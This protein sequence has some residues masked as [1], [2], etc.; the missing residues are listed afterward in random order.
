MRLTYFIIYFLAYLLNFTYS[1]DLLEYLDTG[2]VSNRYENNFRRLT[3]DNVTI[4]KAECLFVQ[5]KPLSNEILK[6]VVFKI[7]EMDLND[8]A[9]PSKY[10]HLFE[11]ILEHLDIRLLEIVDQKLK[12]SKD[13][14]IQTPKNLYFL[15]LL[16]IKLHLLSD[17][18]DYKNFFDISLQI[19]RKLDNIIWLSLIS[20]LVYSNRIKTKDIKNIIRI[21]KEQYRNKL[22]DKDYKFVTFSVLGRFGDSSSISELSKFQR[23]GFCF[24]N[25]FEMKTFNFSAINGTDFSEIGI[26]KIA[27]TESFL[28]IYNLNYKNHKVY[29]YG[30]IN[31]KS[32]PIWKSYCRF[33]D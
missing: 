5:Q 10:R 16:K 19:E 22:D 12:S 18:F 26:D 3:Y 33:P 24:S 28:L 32:Y 29:E 17:E 30:P 14:D 13:I 4:N 21:I 23:N 11:L 8:T 2:K 31:K 6:K 1:D 15:Y 27:F 25:R 20:Q 7:Q 9:I